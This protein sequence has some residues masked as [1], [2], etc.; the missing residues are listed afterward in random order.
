VAI[1]ADVVISANGEAPQSSTREGPKT[2]HLDLIRHMWHNSQHIDGAI[3]V[4]NKPNSDRQKVYAKLDAREHTFVAEYLLDLDPRRAAI[5]AGYSIT[6]AKSK[7]YQWVSNSKVKPHVFHAVIE[8]INARCERTAI[9]ADNVLRELAKVAFASM[10]RFIRVDADGQPQID[11]TDTPQD[12]MDA[13]SDVSTET[14]LERSGSGDDAKVGVVR[15][16]RIK[17]HDKLAALKLLADHT[18]VFTKR[19]QNQANALAL[20]FEQIMARGSKAPIRRDTGIE[21]E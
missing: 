20:A 2:Q 14:V 10:R 13:I 17:L 8:A 6:V 3:I 11:L 21:G 16:T 1:D 15:K 5:A 9:S 4:A 7:A 19:D 18:G 12:H